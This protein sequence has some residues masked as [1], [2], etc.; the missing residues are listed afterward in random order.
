VTT[1]TGAVRY[2]VTGGGG[3]PLYSIR[4]K[5]PRFPVAFNAYHFVYVRLTADSAFFWTIDAGG[6]VRDSG[7]FEKGSNVDHPLAP[8]FSYSDSLPPRCSAA[9][10]S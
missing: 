8:T 10:G 7:C 4:K 9:A 5:D 3:G 1:G 2:F 6:K